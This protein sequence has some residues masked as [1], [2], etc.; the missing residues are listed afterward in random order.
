MSA[1]LV[2]FR[3]DLRLGDNPAWSAATSA[4]EKVVALFVVDPGLWDRSGEHRR[5]QLAAHL[6]ALDT[7]LR[8]RGGRLRVRRG[9]P[10]RVVPAEAAASGAVR[11]YWNGDVT[12]YARRRDAAVRRQR[13]AI[14]EKSTPGA[15]CMPPGPSAPATAVPSR[16]SPR[17]TR[18]AGPAL[19]SLAGARS[20]RGGRRP[21]RRDP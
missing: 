13:W 2:W 1:G 18:L 5:N 17:S 10:A 3:A 4:H 6:G 15:T 14:A 9:D 20:G 7:S 12:P 16:C 21:G 19:G 11:V 8:S